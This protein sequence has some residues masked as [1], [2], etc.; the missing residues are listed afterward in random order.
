MRGFRRGHSRPVPPPFG[1]T[2]KIKTIKRKKGK[3]ERKER[4]RKEE[5]KEKKGIKKIESHACMKKY[6]KNLV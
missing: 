5:K 6:L 2:Q 4:E 1:G 3:K